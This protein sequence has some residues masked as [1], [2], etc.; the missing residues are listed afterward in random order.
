[1]GAGA[2]TPKSCKSASV[3]A[4]TAGGSVVTVHIH[5]EHDSADDEAVINRAFDETMHRM[6]ELVETGQV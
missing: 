6:K 1:M 4:D 5:A 2:M 3:S